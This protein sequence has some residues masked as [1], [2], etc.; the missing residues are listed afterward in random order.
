[1]LAR[2]DATVPLDTVRSELQTFAGRIEQDLQAE[3]REYAGFL[4]SATP[5]VDVWASF[6]GPAG[7]LLLGAG[8]LGGIELAINNTVLVYA[9][10]VSI[11][12]GLFFGLVPAI[13]SSRVDV[14]AN[15]ASGAPSMRSASASVA[16]RVFVAF[17]IALCLV[18]L[19][20]AGL[21]VK[22]FS[23]LSSVDPGVAVDNVLTMR[24][25][26][27]WER[28]QGKIPGFYSELIVRADS[29]RTL[30]WHS[31]PVPAPFEKQETLSTRGHGTRIGR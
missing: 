17:Q 10:A 5:F 18:L 3:S 12:S 23:N 2:V 1:M 27:A 29:R 14:R 6:I 31:Y 28:Y 15:L 4:L 13:Q 7:P 9:L 30:G 19:A 20:G 22:S 24:L 11:L 16:R 8:A 26:L 25:T 21:L